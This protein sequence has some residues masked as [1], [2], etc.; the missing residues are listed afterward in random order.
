MQYH[1]ARSA[2]GGKLDPSPSVSISSV[3]LKRVFAR[4]IRQTQPFGVLSDF[5]FKG[6]S[7]GR[8][9]RAVGRPLGRHGFRGAARAMSG[10]AEPGKV[11]ISS[12]RAAFVVFWLLFGHR[13]GGAQKTAKA[14]LQQGTWCSG[15]TPAQ[16][17]G[18]PGLDP[19]CVHEPFG[20]E[21]RFRT[22]HSAKTA[23]RLAF[24]NFPPLEGRSD[25]RAGRAVGRPVGRPA[26]G[27][28]GE[29]FWVRAPQVK[30]K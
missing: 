26:A 6:R 14:A 28:P 21:T 4:C 13:A 19:Q 25:G 2:C 29:R 30:F 27:R 11:M 1:R 8:A 10:W 12:A 22:K 16:H 3:G 24:H 15:L 9:G 20:A 5:P 23:L 17:A 18:G 7:H